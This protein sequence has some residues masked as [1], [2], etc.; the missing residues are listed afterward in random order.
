MTDITPLK[1]LT[2]LE[3]INLWGTKVSDLSPLSALSNL[4]ELNLKYCPVEDITPLHGLKSLEYVYGLKKE[5]GER[6]LK[7]KPDVK[8]Q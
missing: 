6:L 1:N 5:V 2:K 8:I 4:K 7:A 3:K